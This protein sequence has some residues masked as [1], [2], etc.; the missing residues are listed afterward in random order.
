MKRKDPLFLLFLDTLKTQ[1]MIQHGD[2]IVVGV[3]GGQDS[4]ALLD[5]LERVK[6]MY[7]LEL[8]VAHI[9]HQLRPSSSRDEEAVRALCLKYYLPFYSKKVDIASL[10]LKQKDSLENVARN[11]RLG[12]FRE[13]AAEWQGS[14][15]ALGHTADDQAE[16]VLMR[17][18][19][20]AGGRG[21]SG[22]SYQRPLGDGLQII[23]PLLDFSRKDTETYCNQH[24]PSYCTDET[25]EDPAYL[26]NWVRHRLIPL[27]QEKNP[28]IPVTLNRLAQNLEEERLALE[29]LTAKALSEIGLRPEGKGMAFSRSTFCLYPV[30]IQK[31]M[32]E[33][34]VRTHM[35]LELNFSREKVLQV[36]ELMA[37]GQG[38]KQISLS[39]ECELILQYD[40]A[41]IRKK[42]PSQKN[43]Q[44]SKP[45]R[46]DQLKIPGRTEL[47]DFPMIAE[48]EITDTPR[49]SM[50]ELKRM[51]KNLCILPAELAE[52]GL[53]IRKRQEGDRLYGRKTTLKEY[54][55][56][57]K[58]PASQRDLLPV[59]VGH[60]GVLWVPGIYQAVWPEGSS[61]SSRMLKIQLHPQ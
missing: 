29:W 18:I 44:K 48:A 49:V 50:D 42:E 6:Q 38:E 12:F 60:D 16:T 15:V 41:L 47:S 52:E 30:I 56:K 40:Q 22:M 20:G 8:A 4:V 33:A 10:A 21:L 31:N 19:R 5:L 3:S 27:L 54:L 24:Y 2:R 28:S 53:I 35:D 1:R 26:R 11:V 43:W 17:L 58:I 13:V 9:N 61:H 14:K 59:L 45:V 46:E 39:E 7:S 25:N 32:I 23:R 36:L 34:I 51:S 37:S 55:I 57:M